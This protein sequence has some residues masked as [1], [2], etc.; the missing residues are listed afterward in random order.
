MQT[1]RWSVARS[2]I[3]GSHGHTPYNAER[4]KGFRELSS[5]YSTGKL[6]MLEMTRFRSTWAAHYEAVSYTWGDP[7]DRIDL[8]C[9][10]DQNETGTISVTMN[11]Y[12]ALRALG[13]DRAGRG[14]VWIDAVCINQMDKM[15]RS[16]QVQM[17][18]YIYSYAYGVAIF[19]GDD[20]DQESCLWDLHGSLRFDSSASFGYHLVNRPDIG[21]LLDH[22][23]FTRVWILQEIKAAREAKVICGQCTVS[24]R[25]FESAYRYWQGGHAVLHQFL[26]LTHVRDDEHMD[27]ATILFKRLR[28]SRYCN[29]TDPRDKVYALLGLLPQEM[30]DLIHVDYT[31]SV[32]QV[33]VNTASLLVK[34][35]GL[36][37]LSA[38]QGTSSIENLPS[39]VP[40]WTLPFQQTAL[41]LHLEF[42]PDS[43]SKL[44]RDAKIIHLPSFAQFSTS[45]VLPENQGISISSHD[46]IGI[47]PFLQV[48]GIRLASITLLGDS[49]ITTDYTKT[50]WQSIVFE[51]WRQIAMECLPSDAGKLKKSI[52]EFLY[53]C[54][55]S[56]DVD[57]DFSELEDMTDNVVAFDHFR[58]NASFQQSVWIRCKNR[59]LYVATGRYLGL[60]PLGARIEDIICAFVGGVVPFLLRPE[61][62]KFRFVGEC[63]LQGGK[64]HP[65]VRHI[66]RTWG[67]QQ[68]LEPKK[69]FED[70]VLV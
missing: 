48:R 27:P 17:M 40:D 63:Y 47:A 60:A 35:I 3:A 19:L 49:C 24:W 45:K 25:E 52:Q 32:T 57:F 34:T 5:L 41:G 59:T 33:Y 56:M 62:G 37:I 65:L 13:K 50:D 69:P 10:D 29:A 67:T 43:S 38:V 70:F 64:A 23:W 14:F 44:C 30:A 46:S 16:S 12:R 2:I 42:S 31:Q 8:M 20:L 51:Q 39:W 15:E 61:A 55:I 58:H 66:S 22:P 26:P 11:C 53:I 7:R 18:R 28:E 1:L 54:T 68:S 9:S 4:D 36:T 6:S 21:K